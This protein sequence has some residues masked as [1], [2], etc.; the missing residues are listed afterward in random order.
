MC[1]C[2]KNPVVVNQLSYP[3]AFEDIS[4][5]ECNTT[6]EELVIKKQMLVEKKTP[7]NT[8]FINQQLGNLETMLNSGNYCRFEIH[9]I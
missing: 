9:V 6:R 3:M 5:V 7:E 1:G 4:P 2:S 8:L